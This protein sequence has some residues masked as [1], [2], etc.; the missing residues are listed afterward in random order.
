MSKNL[1]KFTLVVISAYVLIQIYLLFGTWLSSVLAMLFYLILPF[2][3]GYFVSYMIAPGLAFVGKKVRLSPSLVLTLILLVIVGSLVFVS[4]NFFPFLI[5]QFKNIS[6]SLMNASDTNAQR[7]NELFGQFGIDLESQLSFS[8]IMQSVIQFFTSNSSLITGITSKF[9]SS[10]L[11]VG[12]FLLFFVLTLFYTIDTVEIKSQKRLANLREKGYTMFADLLART[13]QIFRLYFRGV[14]VSMIFVAVGSSIGFWFLGLPNPIGLG[15]ICGVLN[16]VPLIGP[17]IGAFPAAFVALSHGWSSLLYVAL[18]VLVVQQIEG[19]FV[20]PNIQGKF[21]DIQ[22]LSILV[23]IV[24]FGSL[25]GVVG[26][27]FAAPFSAILKICLVYLRTKIPVFK[28]YWHTVV[29][30]E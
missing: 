13:D 6:N 16:V 4:T 29:H 25:F 7:I 11:S 19:N 12:S 21:L 28:R 10:I 23:G 5:E 18:I 30:S 1:L 3:V 17:Y 8:H 2:I 20:A 26:M 14:F 15:I 24:V 22:P 9:F 27:I